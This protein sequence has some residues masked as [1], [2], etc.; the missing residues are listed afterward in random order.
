MAGI[1]I[2]TVWTVAVAVTALATA[3]GVAAAAPAP[4]PITG[5]GGV[6]ESVLAL[7][8]DNVWLAG[9]EDPDNTRG[10]AEFL[11]RRPTWRSVT[12]APDVANTELDGMAATSATDVWAVGSARPAYGSRRGHALALH[13]NGKVW[14]RIPTPFA[15]RGLTLSGVAAVSPDDAWAVGGSVLPSSTTPSG[16]EEVPLVLH[17]DG[18]T[19]SRASVPDVGATTLSGVSFSGPGNGWIT[20]SRA[21]GPGGTRRLLHWTGS[22]W[23]V[24]TAPARPSHAR[25]RPGISGIVAI[26]PTNAWASGSGRPEMLHWDGDT[27]STSTFGARGP[28][29]GT[30]TRLQSVAASSRTDVWAAG[31]SC[32]HEARC[33]GLFLHWDGARWAVT[34]VPQVSN[35]NN[36]RSPNAS[37]SIGTVSPGDAWAASSHFDLNGEC[38]CWTDVLWHWDGTRWRYA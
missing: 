35:L 25:G 37:F 34:S 11:H 2:R 38:G 12:A 6:L 21:T 16:Y 14:R 17:W 13:W 15:G 7:G 9:S 33:Q 28:F 3:P 18:S 32:P 31:P 36:E 19:W 23:S 8:P 5:T 4:T 26:S 22:G 30:D 1:R 29:A 24:V 20:P 10:V 27:W